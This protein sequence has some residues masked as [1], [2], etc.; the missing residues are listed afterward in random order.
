ML[1]NDGRKIRIEFFGEDHGHRRINSL[2][3]LDLGHH[4]RRL[5]SVVDPDEG[6]GSEFAV[7]CVRW[8]NRLVDGADRNVKGEQEASGEAAGEH[9][10]A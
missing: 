4:Q 7:R 6:V 10:A 1:N 9:R 5:A 3:H 8:L 2:P